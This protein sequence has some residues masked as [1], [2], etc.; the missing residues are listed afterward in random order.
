[1]K[2]EKIVTKTMVQSFTSWAGYG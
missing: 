2:S 1:M